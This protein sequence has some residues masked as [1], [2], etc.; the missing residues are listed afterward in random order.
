MND[1]KFIIL[2]IGEIVMTLDIIA[3]F[4]LSYTLEGYHGLVIDYRK[5]AER[6]VYHG[7]FVKDLVICLPIYEL[8]MLSPSLEIFSLI[9][10]ARILQ[11]FDYISKNRVM[12]LIR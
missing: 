3:T 8:R 2:L 5:I 10:T 4:F 11:L 7:T 9:K 1:K 6:Y 12:P